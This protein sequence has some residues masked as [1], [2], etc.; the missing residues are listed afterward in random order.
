MKNPQATVWQNHLLEAGRLGRIAAPL[1]LASLVTMSISITDV[2]MMGWLGATELAAGAA[3]SDYYSLFFYLSAGIVAAIAPMISQARGAR[4]VGRI[5]NIVQ[6]GFLLAM[7]LSIPGAIVVF[8]A[9]AAL[10]A[11][12]IDETIVETGAP[13]GQMM[14]ITYF[15]MMAVNVMH[16][17]LSAHDRTRVILVVT[18][19]AL[20]FNALGNYTL[21]FGNFGFEAMGLAGA[22]FASALSATFM[23]CTLLFYATTNRKLKRYHLL[24]RLSR[25]KHNHYPEM[26]RIGMPIGISNLGEMGVFLFSTVTMGVFGAEVLAAHTVAL[27]MAGVVF[28]F[29]LGFAQA[30]TVRIGYAVGS[31]DWQSVMRT[32]RTALVMCVSAGLLTLLCLVSFSREIS[33]A[34]L[35]QGASS[36][37]IMQSAFFLVILAISEPFTNL[38]TVGAGIL[39]GFKDTRVPMLFS[40]LS[41]WGISFVGG[42]SMAFLFDMDGPGIWFGLTGG[43]IA[44][45]LM[46]AFR[47]YRRYAKWPGVQY[48]L[49]N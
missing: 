44:Y 29:P 5:R 13:Y 40:L 46:M 1:I 15:A 27:R 21:M 2:V 45:G 38:G 4:Q 14:A 31:N 37:I 16:Y 49:A 48:A 42:W 32:I 6:Q 36:Y 18:A 39:R 47:L 25:Q 11:I 3:V 8:N 24:N 30:A 35:G 43:S 28:A 34:F 17:F 19:L 23:F 33:Q 20:P 41:F 7:L 26:F 9:D 22:G 12:G 10:Q